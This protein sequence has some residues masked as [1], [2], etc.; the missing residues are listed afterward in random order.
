MDI[1]NAND[2]N[3]WVANVL[4]KNMVKLVLH[5]KEFKIIFDEIKRDCLE[6]VEASFTPMDAQGICD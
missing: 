1:L 4:T 5:S 6:K 2:V 3:T